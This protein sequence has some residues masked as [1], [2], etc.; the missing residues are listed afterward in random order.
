MDIGGVDPR[1]RRIVDV[2]CPG[3][4]EAENNRWANLDLL[5]PWV[6]A[7]AKVRGSVLLPGSVVHAGAVV[8]RAIL[9]ADSVVGEGARVDDLAVLGDGASV[10]PGL[11]ISGGSVG[12]G[13]HLTAEGAS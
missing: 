3:S 11:R 2:K 7:G 5:T 12:V 6:E 4:G 1:V 10:A 8:E 9:G 13:E